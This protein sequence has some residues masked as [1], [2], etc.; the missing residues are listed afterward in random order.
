M[1]TLKQDYKDWKK[2]KAEAKFSTSKMNECKNKL[3]ALMSFDEW[4]K[5][6]DKIKVVSDSLEKDKDET[7]E[8]KFMEKYNSQMQALQLKSC[9]I[10][11]F[12]L[13]DFPFHTL[14]PD[15]SI[16]ISV[17]EGFRCANNHTN[18]DMFETHCA[19]C[20]KFSKLVEYQMLAAEAMVAREKQNVAKMMLMNHFRIFNK[21]K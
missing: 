8:V 15:G 2:A 12:Q 11:V 1:G 9:F 17:S 20:P 7:T 10:T 18:G 3:T 6:A 14:S 16:F 19:G 13:M 21:I 5:Y 4:Q